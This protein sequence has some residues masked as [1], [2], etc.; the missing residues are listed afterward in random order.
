VFFSVLGGYLYVCALYERL[1]RYD[2]IAAA[3]L[4]YVIGWATGDG[5]GE[6]KREARGRSVGGPDLPRPLSRAED[7][8]DGRLSAI[9]TLHRIARLCHHRLS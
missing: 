6:R 9:A 2:A 3:S 1:V 7:F 8:A 4:A 5:R